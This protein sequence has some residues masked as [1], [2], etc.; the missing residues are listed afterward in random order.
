MSGVTVTKAEKVL[1][2]T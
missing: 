1:F 2:T